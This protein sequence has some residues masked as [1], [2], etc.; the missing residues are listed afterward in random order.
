MS[1]SVAIPDDLYCKAVEMAEA[2]QVPVD[3]FIASALADQIAWKRYSLTR[4]DTEKRRF[5]GVQERMPDTD[6]EDDPL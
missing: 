1:T 4:A 6:Y 3:E 5:A 2:E